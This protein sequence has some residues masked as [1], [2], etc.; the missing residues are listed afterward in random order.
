MRLYRLTRDLLHATLSALIVLLFFGGGPIGLAVFSILGDLELLPVPERTTTYMAS[1]S[2][3]PYPE[4]SEEVREVSE[5]LLEPPAPYK[6]KSDTPSKKQTEAPP[7]EATSDKGKPVPVPEAA[8]P[9]GSDAIASGGKVQGPT[10]DGD[11]RRKQECLPANPEIIRVSATRVR[12]KQELVDYYTTH[13]LKAQDLA[14]TWWQKG[15]SG[16]VVG[17]RVTRVR[18]GNDLYQLGFRGG[19][20]VLAV[21]DEPVTSTGQAI[22]AY[23]KLR[24]KRKLKVDIRRNGQPITLEFILY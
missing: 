17:F 10:Q 24:D 19:D 18:C 12:V 22:S 13:L 2:L 3:T 14:E 6:N 11:G 20:V 9:S 7:P 15:K 8:P 5:A 16:E 4:P 23:R 1:M 21:N